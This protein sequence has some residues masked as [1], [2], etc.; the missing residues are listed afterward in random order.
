MHEEGPPAGTAPRVL[1]RRRRPESGPGTG[2]EPED[3]V[4]LMDPVFTFLRGGLAALTTPV[5]KQRRA[6]ASECP[7]SRFFEPHARTSA[8]CGT[9]NESF[10][11]TSPRRS[12]RPNPVI[13]ARPR[14]ES[15]ASASNPRSSPL[16]PKR[17]DRPVTPEV[18]GSSPVAP[19]QSP[20]DDGL[21]R[22]E[23]E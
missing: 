13:P 12:S 16:N 18:A 3:L 4:A 8:V 20:P 15:A 17:H 19:V 11:R 14:G 5:P 9:G 21:A 6:G 23:G 2:R 7:R 10:P 1:V 22:T